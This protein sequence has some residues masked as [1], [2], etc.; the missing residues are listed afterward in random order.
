MN[1]LKKVVMVIAFFCVV[2]SVAPI[3]AID[4]LNLNRNQPIGYE[5]LFHRMTRKLGRG[6]CN[7]AFGALEIFIQTSKVQSEEGAIAA[8][9]GGI[10]R[11]VGHCLVREVVGVSEI[12][13]FPIPLPGCPNDPNDPDTTAAGYGPIVTP[14]WVIAPNT[15]YKNLVYPQT[16]VIN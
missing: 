6:I 13:T 15:D 11:G 5:N 12:I 8:A 1:M 14:E 10:F 9:C 3:Y 7:T 16:G 4:N 2:G